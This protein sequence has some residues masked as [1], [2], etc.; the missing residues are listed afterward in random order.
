[1]ATQQRPTIAID[2]DQALCVTMPSQAEDLTP[3]SFST[4]DGRSGWSVRIPGRRPIATPAYADGLL[5]VGGG[6]GSYRFYAFDATTGEPAW[7]VQ[8]ADDGPSAAV[9]ARGYVAFN[10]GSCTVV[11]CEARTGRVIW[12]EWLGD[13]LMSQPAIAGDRLFIAYPADQRKPL[14]RPGM[15]IEQKRKAIEEAKHHEGGGSFQ[16]RM[17]CADLRTGRH[18]W[19]QEIAADVITAPVVDG[20]HLFMTCLDGTSFSLDVSDGSVLWMRGNQGTS[21][22]L[23]AGERLIMTQKEIFDGRIFEA[24]RRSER[25]TGYPCDPLPLYRRESLY[26]EPSTGGGSSLKGRLAAAL[27]SAVGFSSSSSA[28][29]LYAARAHLGVSSVSGAWAYQGSRAAFAKERIFSSPGRFVCCLL[30]RDSAVGWEAEA[31]GSRV[32]LNDQIFL[33]PALGRDYLYLTSV[34]GHALSVHQQTG[35]L[36]FMYD[37]GRPI[38]FQPCLAKGRMYLGTGD[39]ELVCIDTGGDDADGWYMWGG[40]AQHNKAQ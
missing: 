6:Y 36:G 28:A 11:V 17:L 12:E 30:D 25:G 5:F 33:P 19:E 8:T 20:G 32:D 2:L 7:E 16:H 15:T 4:P 13:P 38:C 37:I 40:N 24:L 26:R 27:D 9:V 1:M 39:G 35:E 14:F 29:K 18:I 31:K 21:A 3:S 23:V 22:P 10:T 34:P